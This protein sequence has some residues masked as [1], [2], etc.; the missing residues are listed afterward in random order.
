MARTHG[1]CRGL[2]D[3]REVS[4]L[5]PRHGR[6]GE[7]RAILR[8]RRTIRSGRCSSSNDRGE[9]GPD[10]PRPSFLEQEGGRSATSGRRRDVEEAF[11]K[12]LAEHPRYGLQ[13][14]HA[15]EW[16]ER[17]GKPTPM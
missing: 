15:H 6:T 4:A 12:Y 9:L 5:R 2:V 16:S 7:G 3:A 14:A 1:D 8:S 11:E 13:A 17:Q 10:A